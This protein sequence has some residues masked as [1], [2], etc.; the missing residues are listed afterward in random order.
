MRCC[1]CKF[2]HNNYHW[3]R[4]DL[5]DSEYYHEYYSEPCPTI[6]DNYIFKE[7]CEPMGFIIGKSS[8]EFMKGGA[9]NG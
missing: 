7:D 8:I 4:C 1:D 9:D 6:D 2:N 5:T 3:N